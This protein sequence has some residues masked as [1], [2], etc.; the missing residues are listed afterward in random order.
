MTFEE[1]VVNHRKMWNWIADETE[2]RQDIVD[3][4]DYFDAHNIPPYSVDNRC[5]CCAYVC[6][7]PEEV[8]HISCGEL[9]PVVWNPDR[10]HASC[11]SFGTAFTNWASAAAW[12][13]RA[14]YAREIADLPVNKSTAKRRFKT[15]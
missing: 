4:R 12:R 1:A 5:Y 11:I 9:C 2:R 6:G 8:L 3:K 14:R 10:S 7:L 15:W 13:D